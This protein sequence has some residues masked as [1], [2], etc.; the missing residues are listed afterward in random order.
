VFSDR[1]SSLDVKT[2]EFT[3]YSFHPEQ[4]GEENIRGVTS[5][6]EDADGSLWLTTMD[7]RLL[8]L[9]SERKEFS[10]YSYGQTTRIF[11]D[12]E[13]VI[14]I[15]TRNRGVMRFPRKS[16]AFFNYQ[17]RNNQ[18]AG[19]RNNEIESVGADSQGFLWIGTTKPDYTARLPAPN[20]RAAAS[21]L[22]SGRVLKAIAA[23]GAAL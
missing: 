11:E 4:P 12:A 18:P 2:Q 21:A 20:H 17:Q 8:K 5:I 1:L 9:A 14:W 6:R 13:G 23:L 10:R 15:G 19:L 7:S 3:R 22:S 16:L